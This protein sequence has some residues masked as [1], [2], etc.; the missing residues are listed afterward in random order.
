MH[1]SQISGML[2]RLESSTMGPWDTT[3]DEKGVITVTD[4]DMTAVARGV[5]IQ[6]AW[7]ISH[8]NED[9]KVLIDEVLDLRRLIF[10]V[11]VLL[12]DNAERG[13]IK[14]YIEAVMSERVG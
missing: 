3:I 2:D 4:P 1:I 12:D 11:H 6:D 7:Q 13:V 14:S 8:A 5:S 9:I 10:D